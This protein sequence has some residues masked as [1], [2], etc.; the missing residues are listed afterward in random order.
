MRDDTAPSRLDD[1]ERRTELPLLGVSL[2]YLAAYA[3][4][5]LA[6]SSPAALRDAALGV[7]L[8]AWAVFVA[9]Y[10]V[11]LALSGE[12]RGFVRSH[13]LDS[14]VLLLP[15]LRPVRVVQVY[16]A[17]QRR[18]TDLPRLSLYARVMSYAGLSS[19]L[20]TFT[21]ALTVY[22]VERTAPGATI[23]TFGDSVWWA[24]SA[25]TTVG[26]G[27]VTPVTA[28]GRVVAVG[29][30]VCGLA[31][32]GAVTGSFSSWLIEVFRQEGRDAKRPPEG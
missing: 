28:E 18:R 9:D 27:D 10:A 24:A 20:L 15:L 17:V 19:A 13:W 8:A 14:L 25:I 30:M 32:L 12:G 16:S 2:V 21:A 6:W 23:T 22:H 4:R 5:V 29:L 3:V 1:W 11:R 31:L 26:Y 7:Q